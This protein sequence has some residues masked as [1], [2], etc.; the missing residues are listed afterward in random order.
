MLLLV[1]LGALAVSATPSGCGGDREQVNIYT[2]TAFF[3]AA[4]SKG[5]YCKCSE[6]AWDRGDRCPFVFEFW[7]HLGVLNLFPFHFQPNE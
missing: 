2:S 5:D 4:R 7:R 3:L 1:G 6:Y